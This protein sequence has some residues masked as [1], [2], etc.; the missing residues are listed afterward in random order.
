MQSGSLF[1]I[2]APSGTGKTTI[3]KKIVAA[4]D[5]VAFSVSHTTRAPRPVEQD[6]IDY[7][8]IDKDN[9]A[10]MQQQGLFLEW[11]EVHGNLYGTSSY[12]IQEATEQGRDLLL[13]IDVQGAR[14][15]KNKLGHTGVFV[16][17]APP[18]LEELAR[19]LVGR[20]TESEDVITTR[21]KNAREEMKSLNQYDYVIVNDTVTEAVEVL[22]SIIIAERSRKRRSLSGVPLKLIS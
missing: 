18:S 6:G 15:V 8:F 21:L 12:A 19:R 9:F 5:N 1:I 7:F 20:S 10:R 17:I 16:F 11:A 14:Q 3:L 13:D 22:K 2:S 4:M